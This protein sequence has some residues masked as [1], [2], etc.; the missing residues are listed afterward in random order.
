MTERDI[1]RYGVNKLN[2]NYQVYV[3][4]CSSHSKKIYKGSKELST[5]KQYF[6]V[7]ELDS[8]KEFLLDKSFTIYVD[9]ISV[10]NLNI[11][12]LRSLLANHGVMRLLYRLNDIPQLGSNEKISLKLKKLISSKNFFIS[13]YQKTI[14]KLFILLTRKA[15]I[16]LVAGDESLQK[17]ASLATKI[18]SVHSMDSEIF[19]SSILKK[20][21]KLKDKKTFMIKNIKS[22]NN[23]LYINMRRH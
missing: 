7:E 23:D 15:D 13:L 21:N 20:H 6:R 14:S 5:F 22:F 1:H 17:Y 8:L 11:Y 18:C 9:L 2:K 3:L 4:D 19:K 12:G 16:V 10:S